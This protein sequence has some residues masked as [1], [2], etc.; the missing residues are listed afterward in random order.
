MVM[1]T[2][3]IGASPNRYRYSYKAI[4]KLRKLN[5][6]VYALGLNDGLIMD[7]KIQTKPINYKKIHTV[8]M[9]LRPQN[10]SQYLNYLLK[11]MPKRVIFNPG[12]ENEILM[13]KLEEKK[14][15][16]ENSCTL[17]LLSTN[18]Y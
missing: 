6:D 14:I 12:S 5:F 9:Y 4:Q 7:V 8:S 15:S 10:Q 11:L 16:C 3:I 1:T 17:V 2:L 18:Q 13:N